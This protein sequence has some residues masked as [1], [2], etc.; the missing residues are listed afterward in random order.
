MSRKLILRL[1]LLDW[2]PRINQGTRLDL[3][4]HKMV[5]IAS[6]D[7]QDFTSHQL[8]KHPSS[9]SLIC[10]IFHVIRKILTILNFLLFTFQYYCNFQFQ[11][12][13]YS[14]YDLMKFKFSI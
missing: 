9:L 6:L 4:K 2:R 12:A 5:W 14:V 7:T 3:K 11:K 8:Y 13:L 1:W 10:P